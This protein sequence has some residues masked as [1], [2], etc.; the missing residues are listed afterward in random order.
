MLQTLPSSEWEATPGNTAILAP[1]QQELYRYPSDG[2]PA[3]AAEAAAA[4]D[5][6]KQFA[7]FPP[8]IVASPRMLELLAVIW[9]AR[10]S[11]RPRSS[12]AKPAR[13]RS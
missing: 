8:F 9:R 4:L 2:G 11:S 10:D 5:R 7:G 12:R 1:P 3:W 6:L 13:A